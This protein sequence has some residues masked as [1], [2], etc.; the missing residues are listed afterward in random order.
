MLYLFGIAQVD[1]V[2]ILVLC[3]QRH[4]CMVGCVTILDNSRYLCDKFVILN[5]CYPEFQVV[6]DVGAALSDVHFENV[7]FLDIDTFI[8]DSLFVRSL[9]VHEF[10]EDI[11]FVQAYH[12]PF[13]K[14][15]AMIYFY[16]STDYVKRQ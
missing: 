15:F 10:E 4:F 3:M 7:V 8:S 13:L 1:V 5:V 16:Y 11:A 9:Q 2:I 14:N 12:A 6:V